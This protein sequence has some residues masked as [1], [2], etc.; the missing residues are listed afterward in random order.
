MNGYVCSNCET[1]YD[2]EDEADE[3]CACERCA[4]LESTTHDT[5]RLVEVYDAL[6]KDK[7]TAH[8]L[9]V[10]IERIG[11]GEPESECLADY[12]YTRANPAGTV[13]TG[14]TSDGYHTFNE[15]YEFRKA[16]NAALFNEWAA[17]GKYNIHKSK[18]HF[19]GEECFGGGYFVVVAMLPN[20]QISNHY[21][22]D[23]WD[24]F[25]VPAFDKAKFKYD[26]HVG[27][28]VLQRLNSLPIDNMFQPPPEQSND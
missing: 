27:A 5:M 22:L 13:I 23:D 4:D 1:S 15:L 10:A 16:Y 18:R 19:E 12:G 9:W 6:H 24:M 14:E 20:G 26:G 21:K 11:A 8:W 25:N 28:D 7:V 17:S 3:C 2:T